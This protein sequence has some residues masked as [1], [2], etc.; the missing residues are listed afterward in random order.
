M[1]AQMPAGIFRAENT[2]ALEFRHDVAGK[3]LDAGGVMRR[4]G[5]EPVAGIGLMPFLHC[6]GDRGWRADE[7]QIAA[8]GKETRRLQ[9]RQIVATGK[10][11]ERTAMRLAGIGFGKV[12][13]GPVEI[14]LPEVDAAR[15]RHQMRDREF[16]GNELPHAHAQFPGFLIRRPDDGRGADE[17]LD[18]VRVASET[19]GAAADVL[20]ERPTFR[21]VGLQGEDHIGRARRELASGFGRSGLEDHRPALRA[22]AHGERPANLEELPLVLEEMH[23]RDVEIDAFLLVAEDRAVLPGIPQAGHDIDEFGGPLI[24]RVVLDMRLEAEILRL[25]LIER[26]HEI[27]AGAAVADEVDRGEPARD[28]IGLVVGRC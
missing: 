9:D 7:F 13:E 18:A 21:H 19:D 5:E 3:S 23:L 28:I 6:V 25:V 27:P 1:I 4:H 24:A 20:A 8:L 16:F 15:M 22:A 10:R 14:V 2:A 12:G 26:G 11:D 17:D